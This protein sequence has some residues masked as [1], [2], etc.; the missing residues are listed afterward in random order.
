MIFWEVLKKFT[1]RNDRLNP[2]EVMY[3]ED[4]T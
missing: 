1:P 3:S 2:L 4:I